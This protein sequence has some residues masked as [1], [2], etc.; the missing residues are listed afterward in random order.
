MNLEDSCNHHHDYDLIQ[1]VNSNADKIMKSGSFFFGVWRISSSIHFNCTQISKKN[2]A[3]K[4]KCNCMM[5]R[6]F[7]Q[8][9][10]KRNK[11]KTFYGKIDLSTS[12]PRPS[13]S[14]F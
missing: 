6:R 14:W 11:N 1:S 4:L 2:R 12:I 5:S 8:Q 13:S 10:M 3:K 9:E 7:E